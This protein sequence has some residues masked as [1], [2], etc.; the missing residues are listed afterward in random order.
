MKNLSK[1]SNYRLKSNIMSGIPKYVFIVDSSIK[2][3]LLDN[4]VR[5][6]LVMARDNN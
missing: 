3:L 1:N 6:I 2:Y 4:D 5:E